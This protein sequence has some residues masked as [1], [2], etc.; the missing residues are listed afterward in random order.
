MI[1]DIEKILYTSQDLDKTVKEL[2]KKIS[3][4]YKN[5]KLLL[6]CILKGSVVFMAD[7]MRAI[8]V[9][10]EIEF[11]RASSYGSSTVSNGDVALSDGFNMDVSGY[12]IL[13]V[14]DILD[15]GRTL[16]AIVKEL[17]KKGPESIRIAALMDK[18]ERRAAGIDIKADY[19]GG[20]VPNEFI[21]GYGLDYNQK[22]RNLPF[23]GVLK[24]EKYS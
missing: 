4:D 16:N 9:E 13:L 14:E 6:I 12:D 20:K 21:V 15:S 10:C 18:P 19:V 1:E 24:P 5:K 7:L 3:E 23:I 11:L 8:S 2:G 17:E 22:Y